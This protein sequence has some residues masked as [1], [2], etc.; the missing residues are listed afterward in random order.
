MPALITG[1]IGAIGAALLATLSGHGLPMIFLAYTL[2]G[3][4]G[5][6]LGAWRI[7]LV[8]DARSSTSS[9]AVKKAF[10]VEK[11]KSIGPL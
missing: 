8:K 3:V 5:L 1:F 6:L 2:G 10:I 4:S 11:D 9:V 7:A